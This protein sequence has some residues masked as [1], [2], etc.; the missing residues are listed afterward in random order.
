MAR[1]QVGRDASPIVLAHTAQRWSSGMVK[2]PSAPDTA[3]QRSEK[4]GVY[5]LLV[6]GI[7]F[8]GAAITI[9]GVAG[10]SHATVGVGGGV[11]AAAGLNFNLLWS[12][13]TRPN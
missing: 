11:I 12:C 9:I 8:L 10:S 7:A 13:R 4:F 6:L 2:I 3:P 5:L 1:Q